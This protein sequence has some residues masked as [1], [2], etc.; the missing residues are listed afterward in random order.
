M[1][2]CFQSGKLHVI[3]EVLMRV[4]FIEFRV[5]ITTFL[6]YCLQAGSNHYYSQLLSRGL[7]SYG[8]YHKGYVVSCR[9]HGPL[10]VF[11]S[12]CLSCRSEL[13]MKGGV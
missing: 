13:T 2:A 6:S 10:I 9:F 11:L 1:Q 12:V 8:I 4:Q 3:V 7:F 5:A